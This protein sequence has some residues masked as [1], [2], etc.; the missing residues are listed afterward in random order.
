MIYR[1]VIHRQAFCRETQLTDKAIVQPTHRS[2]TVSGTVLA[3]IC[4]ASF[5]TGCEPPIWGKSGR[6]VLEMGLLSSLVV[7]L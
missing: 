3:A 7:S 6:R 5:D 2:S 4:D 1:P